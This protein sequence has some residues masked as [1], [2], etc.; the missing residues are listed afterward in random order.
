MRGTL[1]G[2]YRRIETKVTATEPPE[3]DDSSGQVKLTEE[4]AMKLPVQKCILT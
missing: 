2:K 1:L 4:T 3:S